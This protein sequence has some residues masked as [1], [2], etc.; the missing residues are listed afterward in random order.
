M[1]GVPSGV[2]KLE[3]DK[4][5]HR[6]PMRSFPFGTAALSIL[7]LSLLSGAW[8]ALHPA[9]SKK[10]TITLWVFSKEH[11]ASYLNAIPA[12]EKAHPGVTVDC[13]LLANNALSARLQAAFLADVDV[14]DLVEIEIS[15]AGAF[16]RG[17]LE[18]VGFLD[19][20]DRL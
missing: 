6:S 5:L 17:P 12:F 10:A 20:T 11:R 2:S 4:G 1:E 8:L 9:T 19:L 7:I 15:S 14:P 13:Q 3:G 18:R 16:F